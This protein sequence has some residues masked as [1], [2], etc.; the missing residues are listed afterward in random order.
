MTP[1][2]GYH[3][4]QRVGDLKV[5]RPRPFYCLLKS[6]IRHLGAAF[7]LLRASFLT[8]SGACG[9]VQLR[10][11]KA[12]PRF[13]YPVRAMVVSSEAEHRQILVCAV[14]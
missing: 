10:R 8:S 11:R 12:V 5:F 9:L 4:S 13:S 14:E 3:A 2:L 7:Y 1:H 6:D